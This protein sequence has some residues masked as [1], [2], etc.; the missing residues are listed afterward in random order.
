MHFWFV[1]IIIGRDSVALLSST[2]KIRGFLATFCLG[3]DWRAVIITLYFAI[4]FKH[5]MLRN[6]SLLSTQ[7]SQRGI[8]ILQNNCAQRHLTE[9]LRHKFI[10]RMINTFPIMTLL[11]HIFEPV[12][13]VFF[14]TKFFFLDNSLLAGS[15]FETLLRFL[16]LLVWSKLLLIPQFDYTFNISI[17]FV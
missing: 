9:R 3:S 17:N 5:Y 16:W 8:L 15:L 4:T 10:S 6:R 1:T 7:K 2:L 12:S 11:H 14:E 13:R